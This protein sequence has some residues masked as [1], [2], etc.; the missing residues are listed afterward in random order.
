[1]THKTV[2]HREKATLD[3]RVDEVISKAI[4]LKNN[5][6]KQSLKRIFCAFEPDENLSRDNDDEELATISDMLARSMGWVDF[7]ELRERLSIERYS[8]PEL[9]R[10][11][12]VSTMYNQ[13]DFVAKLDTLDPS[14]LEKSVAMQLATIDRKSLEYFHSDNVND[15]I[16]AFDW[17]PLVYLCCS[18]FGRDIPEL[19]RRRIEFVERLLALG[20]DP[21]A[22]M[23]ETDTIRG[24]R[25]VLGGAIGCA[26][27][28]RVAELLLEAG[29]DIADGP[30]LYEGSAM[31]EA[32]R[33]EDETSLALLLKHVPPLWHLCHALPHSLA[34]H[35]E[36]ITRMLLDN[37]ADV[38]WNKTTFCFGGTSLHEAVVLG[39]DIP[40][41][42]ALLDASNDLTA[43]DNAGRTPFQLAVCLN[44]ED[45]AS[46]ISSR[47]DQ[48]CSST[49]FERW[50]GACFAGDT[51]SANSLPVETSNS[52]SLHDRLWL[53]EA[54]RCGNFQCVKSLLNG[55]LDPNT[56][57]YRG[58]APLHIS[59]RNGD[60]A[61]V[62]LM[63][64]AGAEVNIPNFDG[65]FALDLAIDSDHAATGTILEMLMD[66]RGFCEGSQTHLSIPDRD[67]F[68]SAADAVS[69][70]NIEHLRKI[71]NERPNVV[72]ARSPRPHKC[73][74]L[75]YV[76]VNGFEGYRQITP[77]NIVDIVNLLVERGADPNAV[78]YTYRGGP[79]ENAIGLASSSGAP[80]EAGLMLPL[81]HALVTA[82][83]HVDRSWQI[84]V[85]IH[86][87]NLKNELDSTLEALDF[88]EPSV[89]QAFV[90]FGS[91]GDVNMVTRFL[92]KGMNVNW[93]D[94][95]RVTALH[96]AAVNGNREMVDV[97]LSRGADLFLTDAQFDGSA[98][99]WA[100]AGGHEE[101]TRYLIEKKRDLKRLPDD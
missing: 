59:I 81:I 44:R 77:E 95:S 20:A 85:D 7:K 32:V 35:N 23:A 16:G 37:G 73:T 45:H 18:T 52:K 30:T 55:R 75:N 15:Q 5:I 34:Y 69:T 74:L 98:A 17:L 29:A 82:G 61:L 3:I 87:A 66:K 89:G 64:N 50:V 41:F 90:A 97:L 24:Y 46:L 96:Q 12:V 71:L 38:D 63:L 19:R 57:D 6:R 40:L 86:D 28:P 93:S 8:V 94:A 60:S 100:E 49:E 2:S 25:T 65:R 4:F 47:L 36:V 14:I 83:A 54:V 10:L 27:C 76:G 99:G 42:R 91:Q 70:G 78:C 53:N 33:F 22:G 51:D 88:D 92:D 11:V 84:L 26:R 79:G 39:S 68:E 21:N 56:I 43:K 80:T 58:D 101:L 13:G 72:H 48:E 31:W 9:E 62:E 1:M 67:L